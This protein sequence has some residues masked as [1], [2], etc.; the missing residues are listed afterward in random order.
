[1]LLYVVTMTNSSSNSD[2]KKLESFFR[3]H[4]IARLDELQRT[5]DVSGRT[6]F[7]VLVRMG[8]L[9]SY[10]H[11]G[12][13]YTLRRTPSFDADGLWAHCG[14]LFSSHGTLRNT[15]VYLV[16]KSPAGH[17]YAELQ[18]RLRLRVYDTLHDLVAARKIGRADIEQF[19]LY[20][21]AEP[22]TAEAQIAARQ[23]LIAEPPRPGPLPDAAV[24]IE[25]L[26]AVIH[27]SKPDVGQL[28]R[29]CGPKG[30]RSLWSRS[31][32]YGPI[33]SWVKKSPL[34]GDRG[35]KSAVGP[36]ASGLATSDL[37]RSG[38]QG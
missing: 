33:T 29:S 6:V 19:Y 37:R 9:S 22:K 3:R 16:A 12:K 1:M 10:S 11:T 38:D 32:G 7:R 2:V 5:L 8:Y 25:V 18:G 20:V 23:R 14:V 13:Y 28:R 24:V 35:G 27:S 31:K 36:S 21:S 26:L 30:K 34:H 4:L 15:V 17:T